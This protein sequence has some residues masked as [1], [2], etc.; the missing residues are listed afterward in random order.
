MGSKNE[1]KKNEYKD[2]SKPVSV[3]CVKKQSFIN[4]TIAGPDTVDKKIY[5]TN[6]F[7]NST[8]SPRVVD[9]LLAK[10]PPVH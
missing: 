4:K 2:S 9:A 5:R 6:F 1:H 8:V 3:Q 7:Y 10:K